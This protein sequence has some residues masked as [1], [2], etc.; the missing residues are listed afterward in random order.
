[1]HLPF[2]VLVVRKIRHPRMPELAMGAVAAGGV[3]VRNP[4]VASDVSAGHFEALAAEQRVEVNKREIRYRWGRQPLALDGKTVILVD[5]GMATGATMRAAL[6]AVRLMG[7][8]C[9][10]AAV[11]LGSREAVKDIRRY[12]DEVICLH[13]PEPFRAVGA[14]YADFAPLHD[15]DVRDALAA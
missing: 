1:L 3:T 9:S 14:Y 2:D 13:S 11:P 6:G 7:A 15:S 10:I 5:D 8:T 12:S 4:H